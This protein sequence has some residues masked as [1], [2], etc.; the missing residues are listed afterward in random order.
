MRCPKCAAIL[1]DD[2]WAC[3]R[4]GFPVRPRH[5]VVHL[6]FWGSPLQVLLWLLL[7][8]LVS[9]R[10]SLPPAI[11]IRILSI[12]VGRSWI[13]NA[14]SPWLMLTW[15]LSVI[16]AIAGA[17]IF[18]GA[19]RWFCRHLRFSDDT[20]ADFSGRGGQILGW[21]I[22]CVLAGHRW[23]IPAPE[24]VLLDIAMFFLGLWGALN[25]LRWIVGHVKLSS[26]RGFSFF[27]TYVELLG[28]EIL[29]ALSVLTVIGWAWVLAAIWR[30]M[31]RN[32]RGNEIALR[33][34]GVGLQILWRTV[35]AIL[36]SIPVV[37]IPW[38]WLWYAR[39]LVQN[40]TIEGQLGD[41]MV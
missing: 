22:L 10:I 23:N 29:L 15:I 34:H 18:A 19:C 14:P 37:T 28:W 3:S 31:A 27:G 40:T 16:L 38:V 6:D 4:C 12:N 26:S 17:W 7:M 8:A 30:W 1:A 9:V 21:W 41:P 11:N 20:R 39:W 32:T 24:G 2:S 25:I 36:F 5:H 33:F 13:G 35:V